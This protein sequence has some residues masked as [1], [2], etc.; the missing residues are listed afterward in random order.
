MQME[1]LALVNILNELGRDRGDW[2]RR[3]GPD[4]Q[5]G[6]VGR[7]VFDLVEPQIFRSR[8]AASCLPIRSRVSDPFVDEDNRAAVRFLI[9]ISITIRPQAPIC[10]LPRAP[11]MAAYVVRPRIRAS[12]VSAT[13]RSRHR[14]TGRPRVSRLPAAMNSM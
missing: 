4:V 14:P 5:H 1:S 10:S 12:L 6:V 7:I 3:P 9:P 2:I 8:T 13:R 11:H